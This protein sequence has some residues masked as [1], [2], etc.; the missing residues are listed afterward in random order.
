MKV[1]IVKILMLQARRADPARVTIDMVTAMYILGVCPGKA[2]F[3][4]AGYSRQKN[5]V[6]DS[7]RVCH[8]SQSLN[9]FIMSG[10]IGKFHDRFL[11][12]KNTHKV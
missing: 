12:C 6:G 2:E 7:P 4:Y 5:S 11:L 10:D 3:T 9:D 1:R 8:A